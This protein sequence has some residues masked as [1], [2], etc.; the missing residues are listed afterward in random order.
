V[1]DVPEDDH[2]RNA[3]QDVFRRVRADVEELVTKYSGNIEIRRPSHPSFDETVPVREVV[4]I[5]EQ[6]G[7]PPDVARQIMD[8]ARRTARQLDPS[9]DFQVT[10]QGR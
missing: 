5:Y 1:F 6:T 10:F 2:S 8:E 7:V 9:L 4:L 3:L